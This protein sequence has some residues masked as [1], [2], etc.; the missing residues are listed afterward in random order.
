[1]A[2]FALLTRLDARDRALFLRFTIGATRSHLTRAVWTLITHAGGVACSIAAAVI[3]LFA[4][5]D[6]AIA[7]RQ[8]LISLVAS[9]LVVQL[10]K[11]TVSRPRPSRGTDCVTL[12]AEPDMFSFPSGHSAA[13]MSVALA[14][15]MAYPVFALPLLLVALLVGASRVFLGVHYPGDVLIGQLIAVLTGF[16]VRAAS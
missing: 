11:R 2:T 6:L 8:A 15:A 5:G 3:P 16:A 7:A 1:M 12:V 14:Y 10:V 4:G 9:H 13:A